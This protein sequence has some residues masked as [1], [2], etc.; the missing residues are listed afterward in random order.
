MILQEVVDAVVHV[1]VHVIVAPAPSQHV[2]PRPL[3]DRREHL[4]NAMY[5]NHVRERSLA[6][7]DRKLHTIL[8]G[9]LIEIHN[10]FASSTST[11]LATSFAALFSGDVYVSDIGGC[12][13]RQSTITFKLRPSFRSRETSS[14]IDVKT[15]T[16]S[17]FNLGTERPS[18]KGHS[19]GKAPVY[20]IH[21]T[22]T[23]YNH[24]RNIIYV[25][26]PY[27]LPNALFQFVTLPN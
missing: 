9:I 22:S 3:E 1:I 4:K 19:L 21:A 26:T 13:G 14:L 27:C 2:S 17:S 16:A 5:W 10:R 12:I 25:V 18:Q 8:C 6:C 24:N 11:P 15:W 23:L 7:L 20:E